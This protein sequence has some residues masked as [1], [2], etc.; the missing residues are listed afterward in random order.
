MPYWDLPDP[1]IKPAF[2]ES[3]AL[4]DEFFTTDPPGK[5]KQ[6]QKLK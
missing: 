4:A 6:S 2:L 5:P 1:G 3:P